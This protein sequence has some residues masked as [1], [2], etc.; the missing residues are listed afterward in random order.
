M[1]PTCVLRLSNM[2]TLKDLVDPTSYAELL[3]DVSDE[4]NNYGVVK[5][6]IIPKQY[7]DGTYPSLTN[8]TASSGK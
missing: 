5:Q 3:E 7:P 6:I 1:D 8:P 2:T 4:C